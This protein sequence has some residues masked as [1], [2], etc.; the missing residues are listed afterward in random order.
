ME[1]GAERTGM[2]VL[3][4]EKMQGKAEKYNFLGGSKAR[5]NRNSWRSEIRA[6]LE[7]GTRIGKTEIKGQKGTRS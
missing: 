7:L 4:F 1:E 5:R 2:L 3:I 6:G